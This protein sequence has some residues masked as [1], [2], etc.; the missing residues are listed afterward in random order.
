[1]EKIIDA[2]MYFLRFCLS[3]FTKYVAWLKSYDYKH[4][5]AL[6]KRN[7]LYRR[8][9]MTLSVIALLIY[10]FIILQA[11]AKFQNVE[12]HTINHHYQMKHIKPLPNDVKRSLGIF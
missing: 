12:Y 8:V 10:G 5:S 1:M 4:Y 11:I 7:M 2:L 3:F 6:A 9:I